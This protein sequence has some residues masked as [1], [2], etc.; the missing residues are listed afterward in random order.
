LEFLI[1]YRNYWQSHSFLRRQV[2]ATL[3]RLLPLKSKK[4]NEL[5]NQQ[6]L[7]GVPSTVSVANQI[8][9]FS[10]AKFLETKV[11]MYLFPDQAPL[12]YPHAKFL[13]LCSLLNSEDLRT[14]ENTRYLVRKFIT[15]THYRHWLD[16]QYGIP[17]DI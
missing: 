13:V 6:S 4:P 14:D 17:N 12:I 2:T 11:R 16:K 3:A 10:K 9:A 8:S 15:D 1:K 5:L 7:S